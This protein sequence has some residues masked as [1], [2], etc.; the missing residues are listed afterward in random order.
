V[1]IWAIE[2]PLKIIGEG[3]K[4]Q[5]LL[6]AKEKRGSYGNRSA[7]GDALQGAPGSLEISWQRT[8]SMAVSKSTPRFATQ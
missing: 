6:I 4:P 8:V 2:F 5:D 1:E 3:Y 7:T